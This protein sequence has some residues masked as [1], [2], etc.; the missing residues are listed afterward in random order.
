MLMRERAALL[1]RIG[2]R[3]AALAVLACDL[4]DLRAAEAYASALVGDTVPGSKASP[5]TA[6]LK[7]L[8]N[9]AAEEETSSGSA[10]SASPSLAA[11][12]ASPPS[13]VATGSG[14]ALATCLELLARHGEHVDALSILPHLPG[15]VPLHR[16]PASVL[17]AAVCRASDL[18]RRA[19]VVRALR[20]AEWV[21]AQ[22][23]LAD[24]SSRRPVYVEGA[25]PCAV[26]GRRIGASAFAVEPGGALSHY[27]CHLRARDE[28]GA[29]TTAAGS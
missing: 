8:L 23:S 21:G 5:Y 7:V 20:K 3:E 18:R 13:Q 1:G 22:T 9:R 25:E 28:S 27:A 19:S 6:L 10:S 11:A 14:S 29:R 12:A 17:A 24:A 4:G 2:K 15:S 26:C 16:V